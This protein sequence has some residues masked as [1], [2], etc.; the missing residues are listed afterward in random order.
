M[1]NLMEHG[2]KYIEM[3]KGLIELRTI[4]T[5]E[6]MGSLKEQASH[7]AFMN[8]TMVKGPG[9]SYTIL[10]FIEELVW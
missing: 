7:F 10:L 8:L 9:L 1:I 2:K 4:C 5:K 3:P 6:M